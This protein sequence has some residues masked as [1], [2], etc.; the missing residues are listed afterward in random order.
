MTEAQTLK[1]HE[2]IKRPGHYRTIISRGRR[3]E[4]GALVLYCSC[5]EAESPKTRAQLGI[6]VGKRV[7][8]KATDRARAKR[9][10]R[11]VF[12]KNK[13]RFKCPASL[14]FRVVKRP[15]IL[16]YNEIEKNCLALM[17]RCG[18]V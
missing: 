12:R 11:E 17:R 6:I 13:A 8:R 7:L 16:K 2:K 14:V 10:L 1:R 15:K 9:L 3:V 5:L 18:L 4:S